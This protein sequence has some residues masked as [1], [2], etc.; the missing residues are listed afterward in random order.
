M[1]N[2]ENK[3]AARRKRNAALIFKRPEMGAVIPILVLVF[4]IGMVNPSF[5]AMRNMVDVLRATSYSFIIA[6]PLTCLFISGGSDL[7]VSA[8]TNLGGIVC[9]FAMAK[10]KLPIPVAI[11]IT[12]LVGAL[13]G[14][15]KAGIV[16]KMAL[17]PFIMTLGLQYVINGFVLVSTN[18]LPITGFSDSFKVLGQGKVFGVYWTVIMAVIEGIIIHVMLNRTKFGRQICAVGGH[19]ET[20]KLAGID[21][22]K[23]RTIVNVLVSVLAAFCGV[24]MASRF[25][26]A[27]TAVATGT[28]MTIMSSVIIGGT[29]MMGGSGTIIGSLLGCLLLAVINNG[30]VL[31]H[32][33]SF[34][35]NLIFGAI[36]IISII[37][38]KYRREKSGSGM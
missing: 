11:L 32:V 20:A 8:V 4:V 37:I 15:L 38:D 3:N 13:C 27:Q 22:G 5:F 25:N 16:V 6:A 19:Q 14:L 26:S 29:S 31:M 7:S 17:P 36:L 18:G 10:L 34:W 2:T 28:E 9:G 30:L 23:T 24:C 33:S 21:V 12:L 1:Q 35:Q